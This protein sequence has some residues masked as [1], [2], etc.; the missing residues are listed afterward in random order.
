MSVCYGF[1]MSLYLLKTFCRPVRRPALV[2]AKYFI[3]D[4][5]FF[6]HIIIA[7]MSI[8][9]TYVHFCSCNGNSNPGPVD[10]GGDDGLLA[11]WWCPEFSIPCKRCYNHPRNDGII[12]TRFIISHVTKVESYTHKHCW[13]SL[14]LVLSS[15]AYVCSPKHLNKLSPHNERG[16]YSL[17]PFLK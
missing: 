9:F 15:S 2:V 14:I 13:L 4:I 7:S 1:I 5:P 8:I 12:W 3:N 11:V 16:H 17:I 10:S 6:M